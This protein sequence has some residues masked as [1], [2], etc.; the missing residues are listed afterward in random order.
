ML[1]RARGEEYYGV[2]VWWEHR[3]T[4]IRAGETP[5]HLAAEYIRELGHDEVAATDA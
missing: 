2:W 3:T 5:L 4:G 1:G